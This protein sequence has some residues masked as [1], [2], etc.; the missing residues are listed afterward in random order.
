M[1]IKIAARAAEAV[2]QVEK[3]VFTES[4][5]FSVSMQ[6]NFLKINSRLKRMPPK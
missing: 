1:I 2:S 3:K 6:M 5:C 4:Q